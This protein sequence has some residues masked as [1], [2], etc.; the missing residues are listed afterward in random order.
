MLFA[1]AAKLIKGILISVQTS[2]KCGNAVLINIITPVLN[3][4]ISRAVS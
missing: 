4:R 2:V 3:A 1:M